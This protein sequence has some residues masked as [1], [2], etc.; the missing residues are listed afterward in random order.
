SEDREKLFN[1]RIHLIVSRPKKDVMF[2]TGV[3]LIRNSEWSFEFLRQMQEIKDLYNGKKTDQAS[4]W[5]FFNKYPGLN[6]HVSKF[7]L[8]YLNY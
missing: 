1:E 5:Q 3:F 8:D 6:D 7:I 4:M 2:N